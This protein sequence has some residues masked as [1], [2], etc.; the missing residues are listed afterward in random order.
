MTFSFRVICLTGTNLWVVSSTVG[1]RKKIL[2]CMYIVSE[3]FAKIINSEP[4][5]QQNPRF[6]SFAVFNSLA[7][8]LKR[9]RPQKLNL[10]NI[11]S[12][13]MHHN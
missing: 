2:L 5:K 6:K 3:L 10:K 9:W 11:E 1:C 7:K 8:L 12:G 13:I 4:A